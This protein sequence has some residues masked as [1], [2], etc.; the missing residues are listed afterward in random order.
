MAYSYFHGKKIMWDLVRA[1]LS[2]R[3]TFLDI[4]L[5]IKNIVMFK[6]SELKKE[7]FA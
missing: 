5:K 3:A 2:E 6:C 1:S 7:M 4:V